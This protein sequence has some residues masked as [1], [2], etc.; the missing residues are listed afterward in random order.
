MYRAIW[1]VFLAVLILPISAHAFDMSSSSH[2][3]TDAVIGSGGN[4]SSSNSYKLDMTI[5]QAVTNYSESNSYALYLGRVWT[6]ISSFVSPP[7][8]GVEVDGGGIHVTIG[9]KE[10][11]TI[12][13]KNGGATTEVFPLYLGS[14]DPS[15]NWAWFTGHRTDRNRRDLNVTVGPG[16]EKV[17]TIDF[18]GAVAGSYKLIIGPDDVYE[19]RYDEIAI[20][21]VHKKTGLF[22]VTP[23]ISTAFFMLVAIIAA[24]VGSSGKRFSVI[25]E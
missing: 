22:S 19:N 21:V 3:I 17:V 13:V 10:R 16:E 1:I 2:I 5:G 18:F 12:V 4:I 20:K 23:G 9:N 8:T 24:I 15:K 11:I 25:K 14:F 6:F 7:E